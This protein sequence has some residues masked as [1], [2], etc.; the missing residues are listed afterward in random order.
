[1]DDTSLLQPDLGTQSREACGRSWHETSFDTRLDGRVHQL[2]CR[3]K[4]P[5]VTIPVAFAYSVYTST[6]LPKHM[7]TASFA[8]KQF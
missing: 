8:G 5:I 2:L 1:M 3:Q 7:K 4:L 6:F